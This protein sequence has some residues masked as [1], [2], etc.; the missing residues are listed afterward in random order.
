MQVWHAIEC[1]SHPMLGYGGSKKPREQ[2][3]DAEVEWSG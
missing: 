3:F 1:L 2:G